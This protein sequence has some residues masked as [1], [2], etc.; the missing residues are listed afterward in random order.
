MESEK[1]VKPEMTMEPVS[2]MK[3]EMSAPE[4][5]TE[6]VIVRHVPI[7]EGRTKIILPVVE[8]TE[9]SILAKVKEVEEL[10]FDILEW[11][12]DFLPKGVC[13]GDDVKKTDAVLHILSGIR[14]IL[15]DR[16]ILFTFRTK[17]EGGE[18]EIS[19]EDYHRLLLTVAKSGLADLIDEEAGIRIGYDGFDGEKESSADP[20]E[21]GG[22]SSAESLISER[23]TLVRELQEQNAVV[24]LSYHNFRRT[25]SGGELSSILFQMQGMGGDIV[26]AAVMPET[27]E[28]VLRLMEATERFTRESSCPAITMSMGGLGAVSRI[29]CGLTG[30]AAT[31]GAAGKTSAPGQIDVR[32]LAQILK[33]VI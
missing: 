25:P 12:A 17:A 6:P 13:S 29:A 7:G 9:E 5:A 33:V 8:S 15:G 30:S 28:D 23:E 24:L 16:P 1:T 20:A 4:T 27:R 19:E 18:Q 32:M 3:P 22:F 26:K 31:F 10:P 11:R 21:D 2:V 14:E